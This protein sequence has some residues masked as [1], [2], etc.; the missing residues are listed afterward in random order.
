MVK[1]MPAT[2]LI[3]KTPQIPKINLLFLF[4]SNQLYKTVLEK[5]KQNTIVERKLIETQSSGYKQSGLKCVK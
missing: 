4:F 3:V 5:E 2:V 1:G